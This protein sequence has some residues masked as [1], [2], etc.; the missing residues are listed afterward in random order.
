MKPHAKISWV[1]FVL[2]LLGTFLLMI[3]VGDTITSFREA[4]SFED[5]LDEDPQPGD[6]VQG[7]VP[8]LLDS[9]AIEQT[10]TENKSTNSR[11]A[12]K[13]SHAYYVLPTAE[14]YVGL[15]VSSASISTADNLVDQTY[16]FLNGGGV[17]TIALEMDARVAK[18][19]DDLADLFRE[20]MIEYYGYTDAELRAMEPFLMV[21]GRSFITIQIFCTV[22]AVLTVVGV[23]LLVRKWNK[24][25][26]KAKAMTDEDLIY[27]VEP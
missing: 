3:S 7:E 23:I 27:S 2:T 4:K 14:G 12:K 10:W 9:F 19:D 16:G 5:L 26:R 6:H 18:M 15:A 20:E 11:T 21:E 25:S 1:G 13:T 22:G 17:P 8:F 24:G